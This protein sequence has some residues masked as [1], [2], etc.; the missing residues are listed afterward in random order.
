MPAYEILDDGS[1]F[2]TFLEVGSLFHLVV[3]K[4]V[5][6]ERVV[7]SRGRRCERIKDVVVLLGRLCRGSAAPANGV[8][9]DL[10]RDGIVVGDYCGSERVGR[11]EWSHGRERRRKGVVL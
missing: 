10:T 1:H 11:R 8:P 6:R 3:A 7:L 5:R 9:V 2:G 4:G